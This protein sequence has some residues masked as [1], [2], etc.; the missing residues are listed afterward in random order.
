MTAAGTVAVTVS[1]SLLV[2]LS[3]PRTHERPERV[4][5]PA[6]AMAPAPPHPV[7]FATSATP[8][9]AYGPWWDR[10]SRATDRGRTAVSPGITVVR[11][12]HR[13]MPGDRLAW[14][15]VGITGR[16]SMRTTGT[17]RGGTATPFPRISRRVATPFPRIPRRVATPFPRIARRVARTRLEGGRRLDRRAFRHRPRATKGNNMRTFAE[18]L[19]DCEEDRTLRAVLVGMLREAER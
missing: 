15:T 18:L 12:I 16:P 13:A 19:I 1:A 17:T 5:I 10:A 6:P 4:P 9:A 3:A 8:S 14:P 2:T 11:T 7:V